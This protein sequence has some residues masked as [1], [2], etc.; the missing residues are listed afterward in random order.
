MV[1]LI[2]S[3]SPSPIHSGLQLP[4]PSV[5]VPLPKSGSRHSQ[6][7]Q[8]SVTT[9]SPQQSPPSHWHSSVLLMSSHSPSPIHS[10]L[11]TPPS[12]DV[13]GPSEV[14]VLGPSVGTK[15]VVLGPSVGSYVDVLGPSVG[16]DVDVL[17]PSV[18]PDVDVLGPSVGEAVGLD[19]LQLLPE[20]AFTQFKTVST[21]A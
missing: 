3:H 14:D 20:F 19:P 21:S 11:H 8:W 18:G 9:L 7:E 17:G 10:T 2:S 13:L 4:G 16:P 6:A 1:L 15:V 5:V 12:V